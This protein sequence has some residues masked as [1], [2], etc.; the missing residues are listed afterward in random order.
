LHWQSF[1]LD[2]DGE[3]SLYIPAGCAHG[4]QTLQD[5]CEVLYQMDMPYRP[6][7]A[8]GCRF[9]DAA[10]GIKWPLPVTVVAKKDLEWP[11]LRTAAG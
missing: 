11:P 6:D 3:V 4:Y 7:F 5:N 1:R 10:L 8:D 2:A 9:D